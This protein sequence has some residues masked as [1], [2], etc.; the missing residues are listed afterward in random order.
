[1]KDI[2]LCLLALAFFAPASVYGAQFDADAGVQPGSII[3]SES[4]LFAG[5]Q[6][7]IYATIVNSGVKDVR[8]VAQF[9]QGAIALGEA[10][11]FSAK[12]QSVPAFIWTDWR[13]AEGTYNI[14]VS[15]IGTE[16]EDQNTSN[17]IAVTPL[18]TI[19]KRLPP[20]PPAPLPTP[21]QPQIVAPASAPASQAGTQGS[22]D[23]S[24]KQTSN[25]P[26]FADIERSADAVRKLLTKKSAQKPRAVQKGVSINTDPTVSV[27]ELPEEALSKAASRSETLSEAVDLTRPIPFPEVH[28]VSEQKDQGKG[29]VL[30]FA[31]AAGA[32]L[33][34]GALFWNMGRGE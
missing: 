8:G 21:S 24:S 32:S 5:E 18:M 26:H 19:A 15:I 14:S 1:M 17:N 4:Q 33:F 11:P 22:K 3:F 9:Y 7:R 16:P 29:V 30:A 13:P 28:P 34:L 23:A 10:R 31:V 6:V 2:R 12:A 25:A 27:G 20:P